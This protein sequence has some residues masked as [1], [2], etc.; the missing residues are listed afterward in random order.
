MGSKRARTDPNLVRLHEA[1]V[2][3][4]S[5][6]EKA[7]DLPRVCTGLGLGDGT[8]SEAYAGKRKYVAVR[9]ANIESERLLSF[10]EQVLLT[11]DD[12]SLLE[13]VRKARGGWSQEV[14][15]VTRQSLVQ[16]ISTWSSVGGDRGDIE[17]LATEWPLA[18]LP[19]TDNRFDS[20]LGDFGQH[21]VLNE[22]YGPGDIL[23]RL[24]FDSCSDVQLLRTLEAMLHPLSRKGDEQRDCAARLNGILARDGIALEVRDYVSGHPIYGWTRVATGVAGR[25]KNLIFAT[26]GPK[27]EIVLSDAI[28]NDVAILRNEEFVLVYDRVISDD[29]LLWSDLVTWWRD[30][31]P[32]PDSGMPVERALYLRLLQSVKGS[33]SPPEKFFFSAY[34]HEFKTMGLRLPALIPQVFLHFDPFT[35]RQIAD[36]K[37]LPFQRMDFLL[38]LPLRARVVLEIDGQ[39]HYSESGR[40]SP[41]KYALMAEEDRALGLRGYDVYRFGGSELTDKANASALVRGCFSALF[42]KHSLL[43]SQSSELRASAFYHRREVTETPDSS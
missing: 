22:D 42:V 27:P 5:R 23:A 13:E 8:E 38:L 33:K 21:T 24:A 17:C 34:Y 2:T 6:L 28:N 30:T 41:A 25:P 3:S 32:P 1:I 18:M 12:F 37:P 43:P 19:S 35:K 36:R 7:Y 31:G 26:T 11:H 40:P 20:L 14:T 15:A 4:L 10:A 16:E 39:Q 9:L 29:G